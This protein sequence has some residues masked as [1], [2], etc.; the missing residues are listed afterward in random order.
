[1]KIFDIINAYLKESENI[2]GWFYSLD[3][4][5]IG[6]LERFQYDNGMV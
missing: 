3:I 4:V 6:L 1:M 5:L 2:E